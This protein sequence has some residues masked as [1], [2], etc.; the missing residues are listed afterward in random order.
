MQDGTVA[1]ASLCEEHQLAHQRIEELEVEND[2]LSHERDD[3]R[4]SLLTSEQQVGTL[5]ACV[6]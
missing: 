6:P 5:D 2:E 1:L 3:L 4:A